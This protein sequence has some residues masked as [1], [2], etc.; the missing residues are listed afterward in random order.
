VAYVQFD[1]AQPDGTQSG[2]LTL[3][4]IRENQAAIR[5]MVLSGMAPGWGF[6]TGGGTPDQPATVTYSKGVERLRLSFT[7]GVSGGSDGNVTQVIVDYSS[8]SGSLY[9]AMG[10]FVLTYNSDGS[11]NSGVWS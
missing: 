1:Q 6:A 7:W 3:E 4:R 2:A 10:T 8:N 5:D 11:V 9:S